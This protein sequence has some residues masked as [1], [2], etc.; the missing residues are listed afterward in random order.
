MQDGQNFTC[1][2]A[3]LKQF[4][5]FI[6]FLVP[7]SYFSFLNRN[8]QLDDAL[9]YM[10]YIRNFAEG[11]GLV[12]NHGERFNGL[13]SPLYS[14]ILAA[15]T[16]LSG[17][18][19]LIANILSS[20][21]M[22][23]LLSVFTILFSRHDNQYPAVF[24]ALLA[25]CS[26]YFYS[27][28][29]METMLFLLL[30]GWCIYLFEGNNYFLLGI[31]CSLLFLTRGEGIFLILAMA[32]MHI[33]Q[34]RSFPKFKHFILPVLIVVS[35]YVFNKIYYGHFKPQTFLAKID[36]G[37]ST[38][39]G[40]WAF[41]NIGDQL[42]YFNHNKI[43]LGIFMGLVLLGAIKLFKES[44]SLI[45]FLFLCFYTVFYTYLNIP[46]Y[47]WYFAPYY[48]CL[49]F[50]GAAGLGFLF[51]YFMTRKNKMFKITGTVIMSALAI[52]LPCKE[53]EINKPGLGYVNASYRDIGVWLEGH[54]S[55]SAKIAMVEIG[56]VGWYSDRYV[57]DILGLVNPSNERFIGERHFEKW[58]DTYKP[59]YILL[60]DP[61]WPHESG[62]SIVDPVACG[63]FLEDI[64]FKFPGFKML[65]NS[66]LDQKLRQTG[67]IILDKNKA[68]LEK[69]NLHPE[70]GGSIPYIVDYLGDR[71]RCI[72]IKGW[73][74]F[75]NN[76]NVKDCKIF[77]VLRTNAS[78]YVYNSK[79][80]Y[81]PDVTASFHGSNHD[82]AGFTS[83]IDKS[84]LKFGVYDF[85]LYLEGRNSKI[86]TFT[87]KRIEINK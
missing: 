80:Q 69:I 17:N 42:R 67:K 73:A 71:G 7:L 29:G 76:K 63:E 61:F 18:I 1:D 66:N 39:W 70:D 68:S 60:H 58:L 44:I 53:I 54:T 57:I 65:I 46:S 82:Y 77:I 83:I 33:Y 28:F 10:R 87:N 84:E 48:L 27:T 3:T 79:S 38:L 47:G 59:D 22:A 23:L 52:Y 34:R 50:Y 64:N 15:A 6:F 62:V 14:Y 8:Y 30:I 40:E 4:G 26:P 37:R 11:Y 43:L 45:L 41:W 19:L 86:F 16:Y 9:I 55:P 24:G 74:V 31:A 32:I 21:F 72:V 78:T 35:S 56:T 51:Q 81:R 25:A 49:F 5:L 2:R 12:Y 85:G 20:I 75:P 13:T 36:Q